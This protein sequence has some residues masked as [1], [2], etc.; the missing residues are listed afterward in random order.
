MY[1]VFGHTFDNSFFGLMFI[2]FFVGLTGGWFVRKGTVFGFV[3]FFFLIV[4]FA[5]FIMMIDLWLLTVPFI[6]GVL[7]HT[8]K[9]LK[10]KFFS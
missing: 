6:L 7:V 2:V 9:P 10:E 5:Q 3:L 4:P 1:E 8:F